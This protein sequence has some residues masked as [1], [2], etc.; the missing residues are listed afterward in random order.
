MA[1]KEQPGERVESSG[2]R[3]RQIRLEKGIS[4]EEAHQKTK[5]HLSILKAI[6]EDNLANVSP[7]YSKGFLKIYCR[8]LGVNPV[9]FIP[10]YKEPKAR[11]PYSPAVSEGSS[12]GTAMKAIALRLREW[13]P[14]IKIKQVLAVVL[15]GIL[16][17]ILF[18]VGKLLFARHKRTALPAISAVESV[19]RKRAA[20]KREKIAAPQHAVATIPEETAKPPEPKNNTPA[21]LPLR[22]IIRAKED[23][24]VQLK[25]DGHNVFQGVIKKNRF[26]TWQAKEKIEFS[27]SN[28]GAVELE[29]NGKTITN[30]G[31]RRQALKHVMIT[32]EGLS[33][34]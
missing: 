6:E 23:C 28:A 34:L 3:L 10:D 1:Q 16:A 20:A 14:R 9:E 22:L 27:L 18:N 17:V 15:A 19:P 21:P 32:K 5:I 26:D 2:A 24:Y 33:I 11:T 25:T 31:R 7:I 12:S 30:I 29:V 4:L 13:V 8:Y